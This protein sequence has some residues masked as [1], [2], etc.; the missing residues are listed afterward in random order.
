MKQFYLLLITFALLLSVQ[1]ATAQEKNFGLGLM[2]GEPSG[3]SAKLW[4]SNDNALAA[5][6]LIIP[7]MTTNST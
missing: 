3:I 4:T 1:Q 5:G 2:V 6:Q 7:A